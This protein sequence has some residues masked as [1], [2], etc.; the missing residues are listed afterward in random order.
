MFQHR[1]DTYHYDISTMTHG[2]QFVKEIILQP[3]GRCK[4]IVHVYANADRL[5]AYVYRLFACCFIIVCGL[6]ARCAR[7]MYVTQD[8]LT[9][10]TVGE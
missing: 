5:S 2:W 6:F 1:G 3:F 10:V 7:A 8:A 4:I 9:Y